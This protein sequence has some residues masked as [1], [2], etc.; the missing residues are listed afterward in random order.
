[1]EGGF[2]GGIAVGEV[3]IGA[4]VV[5]LRVLLGLEVGLDVVTDTIGSDIVTTA[6]SDAF[7]IIRPS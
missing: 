4:T 7:T 1:M 2:L 5:G 6:V 3:V